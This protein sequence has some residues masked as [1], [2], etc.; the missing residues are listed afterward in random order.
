[1]GSCAPPSC[2][3]TQPI[4]ED[5]SGDAE[6]DEQPPL[7]APSQEHL[8]PTPFAP[9]ALA[10]LPPFVTLEGG[11]LAPLCEEPC[12]CCFYTLSKEEGGVWTTGWRKFAGEWSWIHGRRRPAPHA[13]PWVEGQ[14]LGLNDPRAPA[15]RCCYYSRI[16]P[17][18]SG[19]GWYMDPRGRWRWSEFNA[20][21]RDNAL[22]H[23]QA[24]DS[25]AVRGLPPLAPE[26]PVVAMFMLD[27][28]DPADAPWWWQEEHEEEETGETGESA[29][30]RGHDSGL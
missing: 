25:R 20:P 19:P 16:A 1:M 12:A 18:T 2:R 11:H 17:G 30:P 9:P 4:E 14:A 13:R 8:E 26:G 22:W 6:S 5:V 28:Q 21:H 27:M 23:L 3:R 24:D 7:Q 29:A 10:A 15:C